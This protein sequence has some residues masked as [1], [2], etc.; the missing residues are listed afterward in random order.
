MVFVWGAFGELNEKYTK[1]CEINKVYI[2]YIVFIKFTLRRFKSLYPHQ[3][4][5]ILGKKCLKSRF[6]CGF[7]LEKVS[8]ILHFG[9]CFGECFSI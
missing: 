5:G 9:E 6:F 3:I 7:S 2:Q 4:C 1:C 8:F